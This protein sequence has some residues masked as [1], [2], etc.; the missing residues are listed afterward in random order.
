LPLFSRGPD[1]P[2]AGSILLKR[3]IVLF[4]AV[5]ITIVVLANVAAALR[6][7]DVLPSTWSLASGNYKAIADTT[8]VY[9]IPGWI[10][11]AL[12]L[13]VI[14]WEA[15]GAALFWRTA[16][17]YL[18]NHRRRLRSA[19]TAAGCLLALFGAFILADE[20]FHAFR[21]EGDHRGIVLLLLASILALQLLPDES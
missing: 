16:R 2:V 6:A 18:R 4:W 15:V 12:L 9:S 14:L 5:W 13:G 20:V 17:L 3:G 11:R 21:M 1:E 19:Y 8:R 10:D 7:F